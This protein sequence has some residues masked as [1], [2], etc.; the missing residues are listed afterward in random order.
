LNDLMPLT[1]HPALIRA[2]IDIGGRRKNVEL[3]RRAHWAHPWPFDLDA[4]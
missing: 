2:E 4:A 3:Y 1:Q